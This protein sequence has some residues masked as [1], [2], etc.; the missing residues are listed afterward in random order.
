VHEGHYKR[1][2]RAKNALS[3]PDPTKWYHKTEYSSQRPTCQFL[4]IFYHLIFSTYP[5]LFFPTACAARPTQPATGDA[6]N[7]PAV[8]CPTAAMSYPSFGRLPP[9][10]CPPT[11]GRPSWRCCLLAIH[12]I[13][14]DSS[15]IW[16]KFC[17]NEHLHRKAAQI[18]FIIDS[19]QDSSEL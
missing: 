10:A 16:S 11:W 12:P 19:L 1:D 2:M 18:W 17:W 6:P 14:L 5:H 8:T 7:H 4:Y 9:S 15:E 13:C 3:R